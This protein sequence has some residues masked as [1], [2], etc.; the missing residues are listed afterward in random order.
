MVQSLLDNT[1]P[2][3]IGLAIIFLSSDFYS[4][5][6]RKNERLV[7]PE[8]IHQAYFLIQRMRRENSRYFRQPQPEAQTPRRGS[9]DSF[10]RSHDDGLQEGS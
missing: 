4:R 10:G 2:I 5:Y 1:F 3:L 8:R 6:F 9:L 7:E